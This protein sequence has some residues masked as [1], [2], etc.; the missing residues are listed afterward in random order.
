[1]E[2]LLRIPD[3]RVTGGPNALLTPIGP[4]IGGEVVCEVMP[5]QPANEYLPAANATAC[6]LEI[7][8]GL[9][10]YFEMPAALIY[11]PM[12]HRITSP[13][14]GAVRRD[15]TTRLVNGFVNETSH[16]C[17]HGVERGVMA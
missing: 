12:Q 10:T 14:V 9:K 3:C 15:W 5:F 11:G 13:C 16:N 2:S 17:S 4:A 1:M 8:L 6:R 7:G